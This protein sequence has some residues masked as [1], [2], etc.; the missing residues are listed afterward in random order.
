M[1]RWLLLSATLVVVLLVAAI[2]S[3][4]I[5]AEI[6]F[7]TNPS[8][9]A[10]VTA[11][12][13]ATAATWTVRESPTTIDLEGVDVF[14]GESIQAVVDANPAGTTFYLRAGVHSGQTVKPRDGDKFIG[15]SGTIL[16]GED[17]VEFAFRSGASNVTIQNLTIEKY[18]NKAQSG[19]VAG[20]GKA[21]RIVNNEIRYNWGG[22]VTLNDR[23]QLI[24]NNIHHNRQIGIKGSGT[25]VL[26]DGNEIAFNNYRGDYDP[27]WE[28]GG[29]KFLKT[30]NLVV[31]GN[32]VHDN[33]GPGL[34]TDY[35]N[36]NTLYENNVVEDNDG[37]G[38]FHEVSYDAIIRNNKVR[39]NNKSQ[40]RITSSANMEIY[41]NVVVAT[42]GSSGIYG[43]DSSRGSGSRGVFKIENL[44]VHN[45]TIV[46]DSGFTG[47]RDNKGSGAVWS[48]NNRFDRNT[49]TTNAAKPF[50]W[51]NK[52]RTPQEWTSY[53]QDT[54]S[55]IN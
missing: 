41:G 20:G 27:E 42:G 25:D 54:N 43:A 36:Y 31:R 40:I 35:D 23:Y 47:L 53:G 1:R 46:M 21:W 7:W 26:I 50:F 39:R 33:R 12:H 16:S 6:R 5:G 44:W 17:R 11:E 19:V 10:P 34:W 32:Y 3:S 38:I 13:S 4:L 28:A 8:D 9:N 51:M 37:N 48:N 18:A 52:S 14:P 15:E 55:T 29:T 22:G 45:N 30:V 49:Y 24:G 2:T